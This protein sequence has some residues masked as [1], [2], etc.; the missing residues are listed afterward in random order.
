MNIWELLYS[1]QS[2]YYKTCS[3]IKI[4]IASIEHIYV[5]LLLL[6]LGRTVRITPAR[7]HMYSGLIIIWY[8]CVLI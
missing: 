5:V 4:V 2:V 8:T 3:D 7:T 1:V 6:K